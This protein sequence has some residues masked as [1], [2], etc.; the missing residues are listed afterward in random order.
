M[1]SLFIPSTINSDDEIENEI[2][3]DSSID[4]FQLNEKKSSKSLKKK[5]IPLFSFDFDDGQISKRNILN[6][7]DNTIKEDDDEEDD[8]QISTSIIKKTDTIR[9]M[10]QYNKYIL[11]FIAR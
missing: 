5:K 6:K 4:E 1:P 3:D 11:H 8:N 10:V 9:V 7:I 2:D